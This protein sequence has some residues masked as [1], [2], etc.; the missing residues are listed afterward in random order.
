MGGDIRLALRA[1]GLTLPAPGFRGLL[2]V[3]AAAFVRHGHHL[4][5]VSRLPSWELDLIYPVHA[6]LPPPLDPKNER[7]PPRATSNARRPRWPSVTLNVTTAAT[8]AKNG[9][10][11][12]IR[13]SPRKYATPAATARSGA[14]PSRPSAAGRRLRPGGREAR[15]VS[16]LL[17]RRCVS[18]RV[19]HDSLLPFACYPT[20]GELASQ[21]SAW[22]GAVQHRRRLNV[23]DLF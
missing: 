3:F 16:T 12:R 6:L 19:S 13:I 7:A 17:S 2:H 9:C 14:S 22:H 20:I 18:H 23:S 11:C 4:S 1:F 15:G 8:G 21:K 5:E 10:S